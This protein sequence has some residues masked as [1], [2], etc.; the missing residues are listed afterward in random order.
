ML[1]GTNHLENLKCAKVKSKMQKASSKFRGRNLKYIR[2][3]LS[4]MCG[5]S[6]GM[7]AMV[8]SINL[9][10]KWAKIDAWVVQI[11]LPFC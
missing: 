4:E 8:Q 5:C 6:T 11:L 2:K 1:Q 7:E 10:A 9:S 3:L